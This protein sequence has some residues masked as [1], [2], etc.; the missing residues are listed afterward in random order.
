M[1]EKERL[2]KILKGEKSDKTPWYADLSYFYNSMEIKGTLKD[3][4]KGDEGY[5]DFY[6][7]LGAGICF[8]PP[9]LWESHLNNDISFSETKDSE[10]HVCVYNTPKGNIRS[11]QKYSPDTYSWAY[12]EHFVKDI[13]DLR[14]M[15][16]IFQNTKYTENYK[17]FTRIEK[18]WG[19]NGIATGIAPISV[20]PLQKLLARWAGIEKTID[21]YMDDMDEFEEILCMMQDTEDEVFDILCKSP[22][23]YI[24]FAE[25]LSSEITGKTFFEKYNMPYYKKRIEQ[26]HQAGKYV[27]IHIDGTL[28]SCLPLLEPCGFDV[29][30]A[31][32]PFPVGDVK[33]EDLRKVAGDKIVI[34]GGLPGALFSPSYSDDDFKEHLEKVLDV[35]RNDTR[36]VLGVADQVPPDG[37]EH[38]IKLVREMIGE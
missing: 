14:V 33:I 34:W 23:T 6:K 20:A 9:F 4:Y 2:L 25:N 10:Q 37:L 27:G 30:E 12:T 36:F 19:E 32:T 29:A 15:L 16:Y 17:D 7:D 5:L 21:I 13:D 38:R 26:L 24:E 18:L 22:A 3:K 8:Y 31:V 1:T 28:N 35:F 11:V